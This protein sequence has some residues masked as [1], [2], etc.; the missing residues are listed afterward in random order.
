VT[1]LQTADAI[2][3][4][5]TTTGPIGE[6]VAAGLLPG[7]VWVYS[8]YHCNLSCTYC[9]TESSPDVDRRSV[10]GDQMR[11]I[12][13]EAAELGFTALG[14][15]GGEPILAP[16]IVGTVADMADVLATVVLSNAT[17][18]TDVQIRRL[19]PWAERD[20][21]VQVSLDSPDPDVN[22]A[23]R[24]EDNFAK[25]VDAIPRLV[26]AG[27]HVRIAT[28]STSMDPTDSERLCALHR[29]LG[30]SDDDHI[31][32]PVIRR[33]RGVEVD[34]GVDAGQRDL[35]A[36]LTVT[37]DGAFWSPFG[38]TVRGGILDTD[39]LITRTTSPLRTPAEALLGLVNGRP[40][41]EDAVLNI[42]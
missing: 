1:T 22:D 26:D 4:A 31:V 35:P 25:V 33:G 41:G 21:S 37:A 27:I 40:A 23:A 13:V 29:S 5:G 2:A 28:T 11:R 36:E 34:G 38:P 24:G 9:L 12:A 20:V 42:R 17:L 32:R 16:D 10:S 7:R 39:L 14:V 3:D 18:F 15:T 8:N 19:A 30:V 6:A